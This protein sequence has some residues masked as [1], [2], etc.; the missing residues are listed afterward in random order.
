MAYPI[1][2]FHFSIEFGGESVSFSECSGLDLETEM[3]E[4]RPGD[5][6]SY[7]KM[8]IPGL[9]KQ[10]NIVLKRS[11]T[12]ADNSFFDWWNTASLN[13]VERRDVNIS[14][15]NEEHNAIFT[16]QVRRA[17]PTKL[18]ST[19]LKGDGNEIAIESLELAH[20]GINIVA[21]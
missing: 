14:L 11:M 16:W 18:A 7:T 17:W 21:S 4:Y 8:K 3:I 5:D 15:L 12:P 1:P 2:K 19:D 9:K 10:A 6:P 20:E 13:K